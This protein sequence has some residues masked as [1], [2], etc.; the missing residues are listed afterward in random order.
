[1]KPLQDYFYRFPQESSRMPGRCRVR[2]YRRSNGSHVVLLTELDAS[3]GESISSACDRIV[4]DLVVVRGLNPRSTRWIQHD[5][6]RD[7]LPAQF[8]ELQFTW[9][10]DNRASDPQWQHLSDEQAEALTGNPLGVLNRRMG[11]PQPAD[12]ATVSP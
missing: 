11:D 5:P 6:P 1:M 3:A 2:I 12:E 7:D 8:E 9:D 10:G 4:T